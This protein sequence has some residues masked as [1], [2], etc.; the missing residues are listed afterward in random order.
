VV[1]L[2]MLYVASKCYIRQT[3]ICNDKTTCKVSKTVS[4]LKILLVRKAKEVCI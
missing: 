4:G 3:L 1:L 2:T